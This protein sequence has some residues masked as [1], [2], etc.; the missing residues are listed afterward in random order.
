MHT[1]GPR[2]PSSTFSQ[3]PDICGIVVIKPGIHP[4]PFYHGYV[5]VMRSCWVVRTFTI[6]MAHYHQTRSRSFQELG[7]K[8]L[9]RILF[10]WG[11]I[12]GCAGHYKQ[13]RNSFSV[14]E[15]SSERLNSQVAKHQQPLVG[16]LLMRSGSGTFPP[17]KSIPPVYCSNH[18]LL[19]VLGITVF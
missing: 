1:K 19:L 17:R 15:N 6:R 10:V 7:S 4:Y 12:I 9:W 14:P 11:A 2:N 5:S 3:H 8:C 13:A 18:S 16:E